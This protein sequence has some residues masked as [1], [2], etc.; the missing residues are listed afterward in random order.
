[1]NIRPDLIDLK[2]AKGAEPT[3][4]GLLGVAIR[5]TDDATAVS[6]DLPEGT[7][8]H[9]SVPLR[10]ASAKALV[11][12]KLTTSTTAESGTRAVVVLDHAG[13]YELSA[14]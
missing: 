3:P 1:M 2:W 11:N 8:A 14:E 6:V 4:R 13:H 5:K 9:V 10:S 7:E 12:G